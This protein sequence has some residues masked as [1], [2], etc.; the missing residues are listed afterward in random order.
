MNASMKKVGIVIGRE[1]LQRVRKKSFIVS[2]IALPLVFL[3]AIALPAVFAAR[4]AGGQGS[5]VVLVDRT[6][7]LAPGLLE[8]LGEGGMTGEEV[9]PDSPEMEDAFASAADGDITGILEVDASTL[10]TGAARWSGEDRP[11]QL[12]TM[13]IRQAVSQTAFEVRLGELLGGEVDGSD[14]LQRLLEGG[15]LEVVSLDEEAPSTLERMAGIGGGM[16][17]GMLLYITLLTYGPMVMRAVLE[18][19]TGRIAE[20]VLSSMH[21]SELMLGKIIGVGAVAFTQLAVWIG[22]MALVSSAAIPMLL[23]LLPAEVALDSDL[24]EMVRAAVPAVG[25]AIF[26][27]VCFLFGFL[28]YASLFAAVGSM[29]SSDEEAQ[30]LQTPL[31]FLV[32]IPIMLVMP[33]LGEPASTFATVV[34]LIPFF[35]PILMFARVA[36]GAAPLWQAGLSIL[37]MAGTLFFAAT[38]AGKIYRTGILMQG[39]R[40]TLPE[41]WR[42][43]RQA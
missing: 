26:F 21:P 10:E 31:I 27:F 23:T 8:R 4:S 42:W 38:V 43:V 41:M 3:A 37:L 5:R 6:G 35:S 28:T 40:P 12:R 2:T 11:S 20:V 13:S 17:G 19:K 39:K 24:L 33:V 9:S 15:D 36:S 34:S 29:C 30:Q 32:V 7:V 18:E 22:S 1:Y 16:V 25:V 14:D